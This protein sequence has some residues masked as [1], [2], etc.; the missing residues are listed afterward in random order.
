[1]ILIKNKPLRQAI[2]F[3]E[4]FNLLFVRLLIKNPARSRMFSG[5]IFRE[6]MS[7]VQNDIWMCKEIFEILPIPPGTRIILEHMPG[8]GIYEPL[9]E[10]AYLA[11]LTRACEPQNIFEIGTFRGRTA[12]NFALNSPEDCT[13]WTLDLPLDERA[14]VLDKTNPADA[15]IIRAS[16]TGADYK[17]KDCQHKIRQLYGNSLAFDFSPY[18]GNMD[19]VFVDGAHHYEAASIDTSNALKMVK[20][21]GW[22]IW[23]DFANYGDYNDVTRAVLDMISG[24]KVF[25][26]SSSQLAIYQHASGT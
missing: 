12:L 16:C 19:I 2:G 15:A 23:H 24:E 25:Q 17:G 14:P 1:M 13:V 9:D 10:L 8:Q 26:I 22:I 18:I 4:T 20:P 6:Y 7:L 3:L 21:G 5:R 11:L